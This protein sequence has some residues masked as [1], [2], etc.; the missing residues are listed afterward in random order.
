MCLMSIWTCNQNPT[1]VRYGPPCVTFPY[2]D[3]LFKP[4]SGLPDRSSSLHMGLNCDDWAHRNDF[5]TVML[6]NKKKTSPPCCVPPSPLP[7]PCLRKRR[8]IVNYSVRNIANM[9]IKITTPSR[10]TRI[11]NISPPHRVERSATN[12]MYLSARCNEGCNS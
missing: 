2:S 10:C 5:L 11:L 7:S 8:A 6:A 3:S 1:T 12:G 4:S 9:S